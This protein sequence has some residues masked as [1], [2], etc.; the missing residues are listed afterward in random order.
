M[1]RRKFLKE[2]SAALLILANG[3]IVHLSNSYEEWLRKKPVLRFIVASDGHYGQNDTEY[4][5]YYSD[6]TD[7]VNQ[8]NTENSFEF[9]VFNG[10]IIHDDK[11]WFGDAKK[12][13]DKLTVKYYVSQGNHD[14]CTADEWQEIWNMPL[15]FD[16]AIKKNSFLIG[17]TS[18]A[19]GTYLPP[20]IKWFA[21][22]LEEHKSRQNIFIFI[23]INPLKQTKG[24][25]DCPEFAEL[26]SKYKNIRAVFNGHDHDE[27]NIKMKNNIP[28]IFDSH[29]GGNWGTSYRGF[30][31]V[32]LRKDNS[33]LTYVLNPSEKINE[34]VL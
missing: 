12:A 28:F 23:H 24:G 11:K 9:C 18:N 26:I 22:K 2:S 25:I 6:L 7:R 17:T 27:D 34:Q 21:Q 3:K 29:V 20:D 16:F 32:E 5:K 10:D 14:H 13:L 33:L 8:L 1:F 15:N 31:V 4:E 30:R 19:T